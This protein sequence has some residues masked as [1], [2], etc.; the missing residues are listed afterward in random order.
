[1]I[2]KFVQIPSLEKLCAVIE[3][4][5]GNVYLQQSDKILIDMKQSHSVL[6]ELWNTVKQG[7]NVVLHIFDSNDYLEF[8][9]YM[10]GTAYDESACI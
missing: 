3:S 5:R 7:G 10:V 2:L 1:M 8:V 4:S 9:N 6:Y